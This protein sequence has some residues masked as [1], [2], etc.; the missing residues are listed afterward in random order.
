VALPCWSAL[1][2]PIVQSRNQI[3]GKEW[4]LEI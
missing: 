2:E 1:C 4:N 3:K